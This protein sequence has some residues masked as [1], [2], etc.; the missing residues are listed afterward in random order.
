[1]M[2]KSFMF[3]ERWIAKR[4]IASISLAGC[5]ALLMSLTACTKRSGTSEYNLDR[6]ETLRVNIM[7]EPPTLDWNRSTDTTSAHIQDNIMEGLVEYDLTDPEL[8]L[9]PALATEWSS[10]EDGSRWVFTLR[11]GVQWTDGVEFVG[12]HVLDGWERLLN[13]LTASEYAYFLYTIKNA[14]A[15]NEGKL[16]DFKQVGASID[17]EGRLV[18][19]LEQPKS[20]FPNLLTHHS[21][22]P[23]RKDV[24][25]KHGDRWIHPENIVTL[26]AYLLKVWD[27]D[28]A[29]VL[30]R[31][32]NYY[33][34]PAKIKNILAYMINDMSTAL[35][36]FESG[37]LDMQA[38]LPSRELMHLR[39]RKE[40][41]ET[42]ILG[43]Y[44][45]GFN[46]SRPPLDNP[47]VRKAISHAVD[48]KEITTLL[49]GGQI[50]LTS[51]IPAGMFGYEADRGVQFD[52]D[53]AKKLLDEAGY[54][55]RSTF[56]RLTLSFNTNE[57][58]QRV[59][60]NVQAQL[61]R[62]L[63][64]DIEL[65][66]EEWKV[67]LST[68]KTEPAHIFRLGWLADYPDPDNFMN[69]MTSYSDNNHTRWGNEK[70]DKLIN[71]AVS[72]TD[73]QERRK[74]YSQA[75]QILTEEEVPVMPIYSMVNQLLIA[76]RV[77][78]FP[79]NPMSRF[80][81]KGVSL[82]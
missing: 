22:F 42:G 18:V 72:I 70:Y 23:I 2:F 13:P 21:T 55:D 52:A 79:V 44:Y 1:M 81:Y 11:E 50:P 64:I 53:R 77:Q 74:I 46:T 39:K 38:T 73:R 80:I 40:Y 8:R 34:T 48:R 7:Q 76:D 31:N 25:E 37:R 15:Y 41:R 19:E 67:Y 45:Y 71:Q 68:L 9:R 78:N 24:V 69:L 57:D 27:H 29:I 54:K 26:G 62:N 14:R 20:Y 3:K 51:W 61:R 66:N 59:A 32:D 58:H 43:I 30:E 10:N 49:A 65:A 36:L 60:E 17:S 35:N 75:Q 6:S 56:P 28:K 16:K 12:Q 33:G 5:L 82:K 4:W 47:K 63:G